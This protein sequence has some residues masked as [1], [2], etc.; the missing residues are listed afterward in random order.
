MTLKLAINGVAGRMGREVARAAAA[1]DA[2]RLVGG[3][4]RPGAEAAGGD[5]GALAGGE[6][7]G[8]AVMDGPDAFRD[9]QAVIDFSTPEAAL[10]ALAA[11]PEDCVFVTG[12]T[13]FD[14]T[15][16]EALRRAAARRAIV[17]AGNFSL[18][19][20]LLSALVAIAARA[21][22]EDWD[23]EI[24]ETHHRRKADAPSGTALMLGRAAAHA[25][26]ADLDG[27]T[28]YDRRGHTGPRSAGK[29]GFSV[30]R[31]GGVVGEHEVTFTSETERVR[32][33]HDAFD[34]S[35]FAAGALRAALWAAGR[36][37]GLYDM[38][39]VLELNT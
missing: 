6:P 1:T 18:G 32:L 24:S 16:D 35:I 15:K 2:V 7:L 10:A 13:G 27:M 25:R 36:P 9:A 8:V 33:G 20:N 38:R 21:L 17:A 29:I 12:T 11:L 23:I 22:G 39:D 3:A 34:R 37:P 31:A 14:A 26:G 5:L 30:S 19:V 4:D 28:E